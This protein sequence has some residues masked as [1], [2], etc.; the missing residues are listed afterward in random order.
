MICQGRHKL[1]IAG[2]LC[3]LVTTLCAGPFVPPAE[4]PVAFRRDKLPL[5]SEALVELAKQ[6]EGLARNFHAVSPPEQRAVA[7]IFALT[8][9]VNPANNK[10]RELLADYQKNRRSP[11]TNAD[12]LE[13]SRARIMYYV[14]WLETP[15]AGQHG[16]ALAACLKDV[17]FWAAPQHPAAG[18]TNETGAWAGWV[19]ALSAYQPAVVRKND[20]PPKPQPATESNK[21]PEVLLSQAQVHTMLWHKVSRNDQTNWALAVAPLQMT[22]ANTSADNQEATPFAIAI[23]PSQLG[24]QYA[25]ISTSLTTLLGNTHHP[26]PSNTLVTITS[27]ALE[28]SILSHKRQSI[29]AAAAVLA[30]AAVTGRPPEAIIIGQINDTG[31]FK[32]STGFW[33]QLQSLGKGHGQRLVLP[34]D[35]APCLAAMLAMEKPEVFF[36][37]E[38]L[39]AANFSQLLDLTAKAP[40]DT[41]AK[42]TAQFREIRD[43]LGTQD[44]RQYIANRFVR[45]RLEAIA[46]EAPFHVSAKMLLVQAAGN[47]PVLVSRAILA[48]ELCRAIEPIEDIIKTAKLVYDPSTGPIDPETKMSPVSY[49]FSPAEIAQLMPTY[50]LCLTRISGLQRHAEKN[51]Q[52]LLERAL[53]GIT[54]IRNLDKAVRFHIPSY[55]QAE[56]IRSACGLLLSQHQ[57]LCELLVREA[58][59]LASQ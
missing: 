32:L 14:A 22:A 57:D 13:K 33:N 48:A 25:T 27:Q 2:L 12:R 11:A 8:L 51:D 50:N 4:G 24:D 15:P 31:A 18:P 53:K 55:A 49:S 59:D 37:Y 29:S 9:A 43:K 21:K 52:E 30:S 44:L 7:Q 56:S 17:L 26:L 58:A 42:T 41:L 39:V 5:D 16:Q 20:E 35:A 34:T 45:Q 1:W 36:D 47:R 10:A 46:Q 19:P 23:G 28:E 54:G 6:L 40:S 3:S 38:V